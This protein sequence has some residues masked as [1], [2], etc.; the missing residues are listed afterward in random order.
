MST[1]DVIQHTSADYL[2]LMEDHLEGRRIRFRYHRPFTEQGR[3]PAPGECGDGLI[4][5]G[6]GPWGSAG[7]RD[8]PSLAEEVAL[9]RSFLSLGRPVIGIELGAQILCLAGGGSS[10]PRALSFEVGS[11]VRTRSDALNGFLPERVPRVS[12]MRDWPVPP[13]DAAVLAVDERERP[14]IF[15]LGANAIGFTGH[16]GFKPAIAEDLIM[17]FEEGPEDPVPTLEEL[18]L[19]VRDIEDALVPIMTGLV[20]VTGLMQVK[21]RIPVTLENK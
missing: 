9:A 18:R 12:Y 1:L 21:H 10:R 7:G 16:P 17:E 3:V 8:V 20:Q 19:R 11:A 5:L 4:L 13:P 2:G 15:Q 14:A 6:G